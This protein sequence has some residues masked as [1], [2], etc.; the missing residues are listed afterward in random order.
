[1]L[2]KV[3]G[4]GGYNNPSMFFNDTQKVTFEVVGPH[5]E[6]LDTRHDDVMWPM[7]CPS[8]VANNTPT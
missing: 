1:M 6:S 5:V 8:N 2:L 3:I 4:Y 7:R